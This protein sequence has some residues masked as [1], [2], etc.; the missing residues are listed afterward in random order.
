MSETSPGPDRRALLQQ[1]LRAVDEMQAR[2]AKS[3]AQKREPIAIVGMGLRYPGGAIDGESYW[4]VLRDG[5][6]ATCDV[7]ADRWNADQYYDPDPNAIGK[8]ISRRGGF[9]D[10]VDGFEPTFFGI[11]P[12]EAATLDPQQRLLL[13]VA[14][15]ALESGGLA[16]DRLRGSQTGVFIGITTGDYAK[17]VGVGEAG[18]TDVYAATGNALNAAAGRL[19]FVLGL[20]GPCMAVDTAC[21][22]SL[23]ALHLACQSLRSRECD[24]ALAGGVNVVLLPEAAILFSKWGM[25]APDGR[26]KTFDAS[27]DGFVRSE[28]CGL[29]ALKRVS[30]ALAAGDRILALVAG[31]AVN[32]DG[33]SSGLTVPNGPAQQMVVRAALA[34]AG[35]EPADVDYVEAHGTGTPLGDPIEVEALAAVMDQGRPQGRPLLIGSVKTNIGHAEAASGIAG[36]IKVVVSLQHEVIPPH[37]HFREPNPRIPWADYR[38]AVPTAPTP[39]PR[40]KRRRLAGVSSFGFSGTN[41][42]V[43]VEEPPL[44]DEPALAGPDRSR[45][46]LALSAK[47]EAS[48]RMAAERLASHLEREGPSPIADVAF[49]WNTGRSQ[50]AHRAAIVVKDIAET[51]ERLRALGLD[52]ELVGVLRGKAPSGEGPRVAFLFTG[53]GSQY[54][55]MAQGLYDTQ[56]TFRRALK[57][58]AEVLTARLEKPLLDVMFGAPGCEG[59]IDR[60]GYTQPAL[61]AVEW[62]LAELWRSWGVEPRAVLGH[63]VGEFVAAAVAGALT[64]EDALGLLAER[65]RLMEALPPGGSMV[66]LE[67]SEARVTEALA[68]YAREVSIAAVNGPLSVVISGPLSA[69]QGVLAGLSGV[70]SQPLVVSHAFHSPLVEPM[71]SDL[72]SAARRLTYRPPDLDLVSNLTGKVLAFGDLGADYW[73]RHARGT[74]RFGDGISELRRLGCDALIEVGPSPVLIALARKGESADDAV[75]FIPSLRKGRDDWA[76]L[77]EGLGRLWLKGA[78]V[79]WQRFDRDYA[80]TRVALPTYPFQRQRVWVEHSRQAKMGRGPV[81]HPLLGRRL[82]SPLKEVQFEAQLGPTSPG[83]LEHHRF[84]GATV[85][86]AAAYMEMARAAAPEPGVALE[87]ME[88][89]Q[90]LVL[91]EGESQTVQV[92]VTS[93]PG[94]APSFGIFSSAPG[95][96]RRHAKGRFTQGSTSASRVDLEAAQRR[97]RQELSVEEY[98][99]RLSLLGVQLGPAFRGLVGAWRGAGEAVG[100]VRLPAVADATA[101]GIHPALLDAA[102]F[103]LLEATLGTAL[104]THAALRPTRVGR[105]AVHADVPR[106][107]WSHVVVRSEGASELSADA[108]LFDD[109]GRLLVS[110]EALQLRPLSSDA[111][112]RTSRF[113]EWLYTL[114]WPLRPNEA[115][116]ASGEP[117]RWLV[118]AGAG[119]TG[120]ALVTA[121]RAAG[122]DAMLAAWASQFS[123][124]TGGFTVDP[125]NRAEVDRLVAEAG[126]GV[127]LTGVVYLGSHDA[128]RGADPME[129]QASVSG[130]ALHLAQALASQKSPPRLWL[131]TRGAQ[132][133]AGEAPAV[134]QA[135]VWGLGRTLAAEQP[136]LACTCVDLDPESESVE[137]LVR[138]LLAPDGEN[139]VAWRG[140]H[141]HVARLVRIRAQ[142]RE[143]TGQ[144]LGAAPTSSGFEVRPDATYLVTGG[145]RGLGLEVARWLVERGAR[146]LMLVGRQPPSAAA[147]AA[148]QSLEALGARVEVASADVA[149]VSALSGVFGRL[150]AAQ[151]PLRGIVHC[152][153]VLDDA[154]LAHQSW[155]RFAR[156]MSPKIRGAANLDA[157]TRE[158]ALD[159]F[160][161][162]SSGSSLLGSPG[163]ANYAAANAWLDAFAVRRRSL[164][165]P[166]TAINWG[167]WSEV[168]MAAG[169]DE[170]LRRRQA[171]RGLQM[172]PTDEGFLALDY[173]LAHRVNGAAVL[174]IEWQSFLA[175]QPTVPPVLSTLLQ[176]APPEASGSRTVPPKPG[177]TRDRLAQATGAER[178]DLLVAHVQEQVA[179]VLGLAASQP[180]APD[181]GLTEMGMDSLMAVELRNRL[182]ASLG[183][184]LASTMAFEHPTVG[185]L[186]AFLAGELGLGEGAAQ[187][188]SAPASTRGMAVGQEEGEQRVLAAART[189]GV[190][191]AV[192]DLS[193]AEVDRLLEAMMRKRPE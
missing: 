65:A 7:P 134:D 126:H 132:S 111:L 9:L 103:Q 181:D 84:N 44:S 107:V 71:L 102:A 172:I 118:C 98:Y 29:V 11:T 191:A 27:A 26:C 13:E 164:G 31:S 88:I 39:W 156:V 53:Q 64:L 145:L 38:V 105:L 127:P 96:W 112:D 10:R 97:C 12:R 136:D 168:G 117:G 109:E 70:K 147:I 138:E 176:D 106:E 56:P 54:A 28:G 140:S 108:W 123:V 55:G 52:R 78:R 148:I 125:T 83:F 47:S 43:I 73:R 120:S 113:R 130:G 180:P 40:G 158:R 33:P 41:A 165:L 42:H 160:V 68:P 3:E 85:V 76:V 72:E 115:L 2:L 30:D 144:A 25:L 89:E 82:D 86:P 101:Y 137:G 150:D 183:L 16:P 189:Q 62:A 152:A 8:M 184:T 75:D 17:V 188:T 149:D 110:L 122:Q 93:P 4:R 192:D 63:S 19:A 177:A 119:G 92:V 155:S 99:D 135:P 154:L 114:E 45:H 186:A 174:P 185:A 37:L 51:K 166:A 104:T 74:V 61:F 24:M 81:G 193:G 66:S 23:T 131:V 14:W 159:F 143:A 36:L 146:S 87:E 190:Q 179:Q 121:L 162:F 50:F 90:A 60:T 128:P 18:Q 6:D 32:Q 20:H 141:R 142:G 34:N 22:S 175:Q 163:Q 80:R 100:R 187:T 124:T 153:G 178:G 48:L 15:E 139:Q 49:T 169:L 1:A 129:T 151:P 182:Q 58:C 21:S 167:A 67:A 161:L 69:V 173:L 91:P 95:G 116:P 59:L 46:L 57:R 157:L 170:A 133:V 5:I 171:A 94:Q 35:V 77:L 79:D